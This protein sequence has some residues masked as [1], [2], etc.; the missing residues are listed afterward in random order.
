MLA[1]GQGFTEG[2]TAVAITPYSTQCAELIV[3][4]ILKKQQFP[5]FNE[6]QGHQA[7]YYIVCPYE[8]VH[9]EASGQLLMSFLR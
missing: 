1:A 9:V 8:C 6:H 5:S 2:Q 7:L 3:Y 4:I